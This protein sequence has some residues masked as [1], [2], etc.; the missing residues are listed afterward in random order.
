MRRIGPDGIIETIAGVGT[1]GS[2][3]IGGD[4]REA[5]LGFLSRVALDGDALLIA[6]QSNSFARR[7]YLE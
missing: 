1:N 2:D 5:E 4:A 7:L 3:G 6:D